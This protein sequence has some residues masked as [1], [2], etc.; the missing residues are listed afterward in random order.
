MA[1]KAR[2]LQE[3]YVVQQWEVTGERAY[4]ETA[5]WLT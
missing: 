3:G 5:G 1:Y 2:T 4:I